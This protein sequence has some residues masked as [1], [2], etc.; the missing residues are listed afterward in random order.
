MKNLLV[1]SP[2]SKT[3]Y[4]V[5]GSVAKTEI[6]TAYSCAPN[7]TDSNCYILKIATDKKHNAILDREAYILN[8]LF[9]ESQKQ[10]EAFQKENPE[11]ELRMNYHLTFPKLVETFISKDQNSRRIIILDFSHVTKRLSDLTPLINLERKE[12]VRVDQRSSV[13][14]LGKT[15]KALVFAHSAGIIVNNLSRN[16]VLINKKEHLVILFDWSSAEVTADIASQESEE[17]AQLASTVIRT[18]GWNLKTGLIPTDVDSHTEY[19]ELVK[20]FALGKGGSAKKAH[21]EFYELVDKLWPRE[22]YSFTTHP[23]R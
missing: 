15:L 5:E 8:L 4:V 22:Y 18:L 11:T 14:I 3:N 2:E 10:E 17:I 13:W 6:F 16:N 20:K 7:E 23:L 1:I 12:S 9:S 21:T 19:N